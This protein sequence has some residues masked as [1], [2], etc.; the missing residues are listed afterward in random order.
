[1][2]LTDGLAIAGRADVL[3]VLD[4]VMLS[5]VADFALSHLT[6]TQGNMPLASV[7]NTND[8][9]AKH[10]RSLNLEGSIV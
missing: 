5:L 1:M 8:L 10:K 2:I 3:D 9:M 6:W 7:D 4:E